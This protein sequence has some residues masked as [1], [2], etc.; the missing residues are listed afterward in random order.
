MANVGSGTAG[1]TLIG[2]GNGKSPKFSDIGT[3]SGLTDHGVVLSQ[4]NDAFVATGTGTAGQVLQSN[5][6]L[7]DPSYSTATYPSTAGDSG[8]VLVSDGT[9]WVSSP[10]INPSSMLVISDDFIGVNSTVATG[11][12]FSQ[13]T[14]IDQSLRVEFIASSS[15][16]HPGVAANVATVA[17]SR[18]S[19]FMAGNSGS[20]VSPITLGG[21]PIRLKWIANVA[22]PSDGVNTYTL[23]IGLCDTSTSAD[24]AN[25][26][27][28]RYTHGTNSGKWQ[29][30]TAASS[31]RTTNN[32]SVPASGWTKLEILIN[33]L[34]TSVDFL[35][36]NVTVQTH[37]LNI[38]T[39]SGPGFIGAVSLGTA[40]AQTTIVD[41][42][43]LEQNLTNSR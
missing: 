43:Y 40:A 3:N 41:F 6:P 27:Y 25:G 10:I 2:D 34:G 8:N 33:T 13:Q 1:K 9:N 20:I 28:F 36:N 26:C 32:T 29:A 18:Y 35:I 31:V 12:L 11:A 42:F 5:G 4:G 39:A 17:G 24:Q 21:G 38:P 19:L 14:W 7:A 16:D 30:V 23:S 22:I 37:T 15:S